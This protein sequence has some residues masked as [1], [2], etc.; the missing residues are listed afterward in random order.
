MYNLE[1]YEYSVGGSLDSDAPTYVTRKADQELLDAL[2]DGKF[3]Y[4]FNSRQMGKSS[5][6]VRAMEE[7]HNRNF[8]CASI[9]LTRLGSAQTTPEQWYK[10]IIVELCRAFDLLDDLDQSLSRF[11]DLSPVQQL[12]LFLE[13]VLLTKIPNER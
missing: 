10:G 11:A 12:G 9:D 3:C 6:R 2:K 5:L 8:A 4:V 7:L 13:D 1:D